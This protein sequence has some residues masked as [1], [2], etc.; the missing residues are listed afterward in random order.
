MLPQDIAAYHQY[1]FSKEVSSNTVIRHHAVIHKALGDAVYHELI[2]T[3]PASRVR[4]PKKEVFIT[5][6]YTLE[7]CHQ[8]LEAVQGEKIE[9][10]VTMALYTGMR[11]SELLGLR[12]G[13]IDFGEKL[14]HINHSI[15]RGVIDKKHTGVG[16]DKLKRESSFRTLPLTEP[17]Y[18]KLYETMTC[19]YGTLSPPPH[20][21]V[22]IGKGGK[23][24]KPNY[25]TEAFPKLLKK[26]GLQPIRLHDLRHTCSNLLITERVPLIEVQ[27]WLGHSSIQTTA[28]L[29][30]H[31]TFETKLHSAET[32][33][34]F[35]EERRHNMKKNE[36]MTIAEWIADLNP[37][38]QKNIHAFLETGALQSL[39]ES[40]DG[41]YDAIVRFDNEEPLFVEVN[42]DA[43]GCV[44]DMYCSCNIGFC[45]HL[46]AVLHEIKAGHASIPCENED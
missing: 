44:E 16:Q 23:A 40:D 20:E 8:L 45:V 21:Y 33:K 36:R 17:L 41:C 29:Y 42:L 37:E 28:N 27:Q 2:P 39:T 38:S 9:L 11:R 7:E 19:R 1:L 32:I 26:H 5:K 31:L 12:W 46:A 43:N 6:P 24:L 14:I 25:L 34:N 4:R 35:N 10:A 15:V 30:S 22:L 18:T 3:N 13:A